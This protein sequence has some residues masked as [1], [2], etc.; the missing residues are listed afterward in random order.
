MTK[1]FRTS[2]A[3]CQ[4]AAWIVDSKQNYSNQVLEPS[5]TFQ[6]RTNKDF[7]LDA[8]RNHFLHQKANI[9]ACGAS[10]P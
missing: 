2:E 5:K 8:G 6:Q 3:I 1:Q 7:L 10:Q 9:G 4:S